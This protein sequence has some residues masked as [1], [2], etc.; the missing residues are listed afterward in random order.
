MHLTRRKRASCTA[1]AL[2]IAVSLVLLYRAH[3]QS[4][5]RAT[6]VSAVRELPAPAQLAALDSSMRALE[7][8]IRD[9]PR[10][11]WDPEYVVAHVGHEPAVLF[12]WVQQNT[13]WIPYRGLLRGAAG[14]LMDREGNSLDRA[15]LLGT[16]LARAGQT[17]RLAH[18]DLT[19]DRAADLLPSLVVGRRTAAAPEAAPAQPS[20]AD[21]RAVAAKYRLDGAAVE[22]TLDRQGA[23]LERLMDTLDQRATSQTARLLAAVGHPDSAMDWGERYDSALATLQDHWWVQRQEGAGWVDLDLLAPIDSAGQALIAARET[24]AIGD[25]PDS[26]YHAMVIRVVAERWTDAGPAEEPVLERTVRPSE[27]IGQPIVL[28]F[29]PGDWPSAVIL[30][31]ADRLNSFRTAA[32]QQ[33]RWSVA[34]LAAGSATRATLLASGTREN[35]KGVGLGSLGSGIGRGLQREDGVANLSSRGT[36]TAVW[37]EYEIRDPGAAPQ[38]IRRTVFDVIGPAA[39][40]TKAP[41]PP[42]SDTQRLERSLALMMRTEILPLPARFAPEFVGWLTTQSLLANRR[43]LRAVTAGDL[44][45]GTPGSDSVFASSAPAVGPLA[46]LALARG[47][48]S[49]VA[50]QIFVGHAGLL[51]RHQGPEIAGN[52]IVMLDAVDIVANDVDVDLTAPDAFPVRLAQGVFE[53][54]A[55]AVLPV[56]RGR[57]ENAGVA[58]SGSDDWAVLRPERADEASRLELPAD[59]RTRIRHELDAGYLVVASRKAAGRSGP[60][61]AAWWRID[62][63]TGT[64]LGMGDRGWGQMVDRAMLT[65][66]AAYMA[67]NF[68][69]EYGL[70]QA[71]PQVEN[72][73]R[74][75]GNVMEE[76]GWAPSWTKPAPR[77]VDPL[78]LAKANDRVCVI[79]AIKMGILPTLPL[80]LI[81]IRYSRAGQVLWNPA[82]R[83]FGRQIWSN[84][85]SSMRG[86]VV[87]GSRRGGGPARGAPTLPSVH[88]PEGA[89]TNPKGYP[90]PN[91]SP[92]RGS[93]AANPIAKTQPDLGK[94]QPDLGKTQPDLGRTHPDLGKTEPGLA[95]PA[96]TGATPDGSTPSLQEAQENYDRAT[97]AVGDAL[98]ALKRYEASHGGPEE[99]AGLQGMNAPDPAL[100]GLERVAQQKLDRLSEAADQLRQAKTAT[101]QTSAAPVPAPQ[102]AGPWPG[103]TEAGL[104]AIATWYAELHM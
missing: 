41:P 86:A 44:A 57:V 63:A 78:E 100:A 82:L 39:R 29:W 40:Q 33:Q 3:R 16:L 71:M 53:T 32:L 60:G 45:P 50:D 80:V 23:A 21:L 66:L 30:A 91:P 89:G 14:V 4:L 62:P 94:T 26:L 101:D 76:R 98:D 77:A 73:L 47:T 90:N 99:F 2:L 79:Q 27:S 19:R 88:V 59:V 38:P 72:D 5:G 22:R 25:L 12:R 54:N 70:C 96:S 87:W 9:A 83:R 92:P 28:Q 8:G 46:A 42:L 81:T 61:Y 35:S 11:R 95:K 36:L 69:F 56:I 18:G 6:S 74:F 34:L 102:A 24:L 10:D 103:S 68:A 37:L 52:G 7:D 65:D 13:N 67:E 48:L 75:I 1:T 104:A 85:H 84:S 97:K 15:V 43:L 49:P 17:V 31:T 20:S 55:E 64:T 93:E 51:T 58:Y